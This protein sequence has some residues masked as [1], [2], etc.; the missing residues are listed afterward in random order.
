MRIALATSSYAPYLGGVEEHVRNLAHRLRDR[1][2]DVVVWTVA[3]DG[4]FCVREADGIPVWDLPAPLPARSLSSGARFLAQ[5]PG[6]ASKW[7]RAL[8]AFNPD[9]IHVHCFGPN[10]TYARVVAGLSRTPMVV[11]S[12]GETLGD[13]H[14]VFSQSRLARRS[15]RSALAA[16][17]V[18]TGCSL[19]VLDDLESRFGLLPGSGVVVQN[20]I[21]LDEPVGA[22]PAGVKGR[23]IAAVGRLEQT[24][25]FDLL[26]EGFARAGLPDDV[27][28][29][30][31]GDGS[32]GGPL[33][34]QAMRLG[35]QDRFVLTGRLGRDQVGG[36]LRNAQAGVV[37]SRF[38]GFGITVL[39]IWRAERPLV[40][41]NRGG[42]AGLVTNGIDGILVDPEDTQALAEALRVVVEDPERADKLATHGAQRVRSLTWD[43]VVD[44]YRELYTAALQRYVGRVEAASNEGES[45]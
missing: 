1:G 9:L 24:K 31:G 35:I 11:T 37:P 30:I 40:A 28:L 23:Y 17:D 33:Q 43:R 26:L 20:G 6:S 2:D 19:V 15:L 42:P 22:A 36:L 4:H 5:M 44:E 3:R 29:V 27:G 21:D 34:Q 7:R 25:G 45:E 12:H 16:A 41:T 8:Q 14:D 18:I 32:Q 39:E 13:D 10:G 38:E